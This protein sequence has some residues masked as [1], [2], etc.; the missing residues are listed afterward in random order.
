VWVWTV[1]LP[2][3]ILNSSA[4]N[5]PLG[6][7]DYIGWIIFL[8]GL[9]L[10]SIADMQKLWFKQSPES[11]GKWVDVGLWK[12]SR[13]PNYFGEMLVWIGAFIASARVFVGAEWAAVVSPIFIVLL[14]LFVSGLPL[15]E[16]SADNRHGSKEDY[17]EY[18]RRTSILIPFPP[19]LYVRFPSSLKSTLLFDWPM[20]NTM[21]ESQ[22]H[23]TETSPI[24]GSEPSS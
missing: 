8:V 17:R 11:R 22:A 23:A 4:R 7:S 13:H 6:A 18:K 21:N 19:V 3:T 24:K 1:S 12:W 9:G 5:P 15:V 16:K 10:E 2:V 20:Y 14:L